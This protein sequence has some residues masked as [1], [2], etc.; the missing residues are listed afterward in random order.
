MTDTN[1]PRQFI[2][3]K[4][5]N[6]VHLDLGQG[7]LPLQTE[8]EAHGRAVAEI[9]GVFAD[10][11]GMPAD[12]TNTIR[13]AGY[14]HDI[15]K[16]FVP[17]DILLKPGP[18]S[19]LERLMMERHVVH[20]VDRYLNLSRPGVDRLAHD[21]LVIMVIFQH[22]ERF[23]GYGYPQGKKGRDVERMAQIVSI[24]DVMSALCADRCYR[25]AFSFD[26][27]L[28]H[29]EKEAGRAWKKDYVHYVFEH[30]ERFRQVVTCKLFPDID[31]NQ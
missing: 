13:I 25:N 22:H 31:A 1:I 27:I 16:Y 10:V 19:P 26:A 7:S 20:G 6:D 4:E 21:T 15:G 24:A 12:L 3:D 17:K 9:C 29:L 28:E 30:E 11:L 18:L 5:M 2:P 14:L 8:V 23:D